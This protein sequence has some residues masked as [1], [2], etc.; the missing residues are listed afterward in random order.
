MVNAGSDFLGRT[1]DPTRRPDAYRLRATWIVTHLI[2]QAPT[3]VLL[4]AAGLKEAHSLAYYLK[5]VPQPDEREVRERLHGP[6]PLSTPPRERPRLRLL[7]GGA[8]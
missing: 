6:E 7:D 1:N 5:F 8:R 3:D 4:P 2:A